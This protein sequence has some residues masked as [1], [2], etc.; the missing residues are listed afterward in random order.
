ASHIWRRWSLNRFDQQ[1]QFGS[2]KPFAEI[3][4]SD[5]SSSSKDREAKYRV[6]IAYSF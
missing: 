5:I 1:R 3:W 4:S 6:G 2:W